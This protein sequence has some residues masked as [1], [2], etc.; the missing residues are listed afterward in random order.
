MAFHTHK[1][2]VSFALGSS[3]LLNSLKVL[4]LFILV[5]QYFI[6]AISSKNTDFSQKVHIINFFILSILATFQST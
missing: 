6:L 5:T 1:N 4:V 2:T 3:F